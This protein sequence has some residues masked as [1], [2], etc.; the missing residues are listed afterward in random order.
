MHSSRNPPAAPFS[1]LGPSRRRDE[2]EKVVAV[3]T[4]AQRFFCPLR[5]LAASFAVAGASTACSGDH[6]LL[7]QRPID[8]A[9]PMDVGGAADVRAEESRTGVPPADAREASLEDRFDASEPPEPPE[10]PG[11]WTFTWLNGLVDAP[12]VRFCFVPVTGDREMRDR[13][14]P[15]P[16]GGLVFGKSLVLTELREVDLST[17]GVQPYAVVGGDAGAEGGLGCA[18][19]LDAQ[20]GAVADDG[21]LR[22]PVAVALPLIPAG[23]LTEGR[24][25]L[26]VATGCAL[27]WPYAD[28][29]ADADAGSISDAGDSEA[30]RDADAGGDADFDADAAVRADVAEGG[31]DAARGGDGSFDATED[32]FRIPDRAATCGG[33][34]RAPTA[35]LV[36][37]RLSRREVGAS[38]GLQAVHASTAV[39]GARIVVERMGGSAPVFSAELMPN[40]IVPRDGLSA[41]AR[42]DFGSSI[43]A[44]ALRVASPVSAFP[45]AVF[46]LGSA[47]AA[48]GIE[49]SSL[50]EGD[51]LSLVLIGAQP[52]QNPGP[53]RNAARV[54]I[55]RN[56]PPGGAD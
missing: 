40:Q 56:A 36:L 52:G 18:A 2:P 47:L 17:M 5:T 6:D 16:A 33:S 50:V 46:S 19:I 43:G 54:A 11:R 29:D 30:G 35:G 23:T 41:V 20:D 39:A 27:R 13:V 44:A 7:A 10:P 32:V 24:S 25:Y 1:V 42:D 14:A 21:A 15:V 34:S 53:A 3:P 49:E 26:G 12:S 48:S 8:A 9:M 55:V 31:S 28:P 51:V 45:S 37:V 22:G 38:F 4:A